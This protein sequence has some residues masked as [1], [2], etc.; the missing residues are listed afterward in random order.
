[1]ITSPNSS[2]DTIG[3]A[4]QQKQAMHAV[5]EQF[6]DELLE[7][8]SRPPQ[9]IDQLMGQEEFFLAPD[10][11]TSRKD[12]PT[13]VMVKDI[14]RGLLAVSV[15][16][17]GSSYPD[18]G[19]RLVY[20]LM[21]AGDW[22]RYGF[23]VQGDPKLVLQYQQHHDHLLSIER[24]WD[25]QC[26]YQFRDSGGMLV[27][28]RFKEPDFYD[29]YVTRERFK[30]ITRHLHFR[31][32]RSILSVFEEPSSDD[33]FN[34]EVDMGDFINQ[35]SL[36]EFEKGESSLQSS[37]KSGLA[38]DLFGGRSWDDS[39]PSTVQEKDLKEGKVFTTED[40]S[41]D[42]GL[43]V[44]NQDPENIEKEHSHRNSKKQDPFFDNLDD[45]DDL[46]S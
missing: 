15:T 6:F 3:K 10:F 13:T 23:L 26:D 14:E 28:W 2:Q 32:G 4:N 9:A 31:L 8:W 21:Q 25:R 37:E 22:L 30:I 27:E 33:E 29:N 5:R 40:I 11:S 20:S 24:I 45:T 7:E 39:T 17:K 42:F 19:I 41:D 35:E 1:M 38:F 36:M 34:E 44:S 46:V 43:D 12:D 16:P 18:K